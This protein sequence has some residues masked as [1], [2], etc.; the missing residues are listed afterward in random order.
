MNNAA[1]NIGAQAEV[2]PQKTPGI[3]LGAM[4]IPD[5]FRDLPDA[6]VIAD[7]HQRITWVN[8]AFQ[9]L[10]GYDKEELI[11]KNAER[12][13]ADPNSFERQTRGR[14]AADPGA[15]DHN[16]EMRYLRKDGSS[17]LTQTT[18]GPIHDRDGQFL[19]L[20]A[21]IKDIS[22]SRAIENLLHRLFEISAD[23]DMESTTKIQ[24]ILELGCEHFQTDSALVSW[25][26]GDS[27]TILYS[28]SDLVDIP[29][30]SSFQLGE[31]Y[32]S[33]MLKSNAPMA[34]HNAK[35]SQF[36]SH[37]CYDLFLLETYIGVPLI[38]DGAR[39]G[40][41][42]FTSP[43][44]RHPFEPHDLEIIKMFAAWISQQLNV[45][46]ATNQLPTAP[47]RPE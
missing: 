42:N 31:T 9:A 36:A 28:H 15:Q 4:R 19:G 47:P 45:E 13:Y 25:V 24:T 18:G 39:F 43:E 34:C 46:K 12:L 6:V 20:F 44:A 14:F 40:T 1:I 26:R 37:P 16:F 21:I 8:T 5:L 11:G 27:Y 29:R 2:K 7:E 3:S 23:Q 30:G 10:F 17:F 41:L 38:V 35:Q 32:C 22:Q 33:E